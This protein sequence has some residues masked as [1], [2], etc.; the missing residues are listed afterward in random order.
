[1]QQFD[2]PIIHKTYELY[3]S[4][5][6]LEKTIPKMDRFTLWQ[7][8]ENSALDVLEGLFAKHLCDEGANNGHAGGAAD[9]DDTVELLGLEAGVL[10]R[11]ADRGAGAREE[12]LHELVEARARDGEL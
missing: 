9:E 12:R 1:M 5:H 6:D 3:R 11:A 4:L 10:E 2:I 8:A 7:R